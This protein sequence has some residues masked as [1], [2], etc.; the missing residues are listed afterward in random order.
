MCKNYLE[1]IEKEKKN[2]FAY[3]PE[4]GIN[5]GHF[6]NKQQDIFALFII[7]QRIVLMG[8]YGTAW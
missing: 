8:Y 2:L 6:G 1:E 3:Y 4:W 5:V 7:L